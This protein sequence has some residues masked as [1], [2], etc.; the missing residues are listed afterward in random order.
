MSNTSS[1]TSLGFVSAAA[2]GLLLVA[3][4]GSSFAGH[5]APSQH[6]S[7]RVNAGAPASGPSQSPITSRNN[8]PAG[9]GTT[10]VPH[11]Q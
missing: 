6:P 11:Q 4:T 10:K 1:K 5:T 7:S 8:G 2:A 9:G 3:M